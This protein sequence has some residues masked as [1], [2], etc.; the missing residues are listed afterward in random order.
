M[1]NEFSSKFKNRI[2]LYLG[3]KNSIYEKKLK[4][5]KSKLSENKKSDNGKKSLI[6]EEED[7]R[8]E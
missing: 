7:L 2:D 4:E 5:L 3:L 1:I 8:D 6:T